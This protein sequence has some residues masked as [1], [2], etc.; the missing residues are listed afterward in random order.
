MIPA[1]V[2]AVVDGRD[3]RVCVYDGQPATDRHHRRFGMGGSSLPDHQS[4]Q[5]IISLCGFGNTS[6]CH[7]RAH[8]DR[9]WALANGYRVPHGTDPLTV[10]ITHHAWGLVWLTAD[11][12]FSLEPQEIPA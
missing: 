4:P 10:P 1:Q 11:G 2:R 12:G 3:E 8:T 9:E 6:G 7:G 5:N